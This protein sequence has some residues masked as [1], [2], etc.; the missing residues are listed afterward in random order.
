MG[1]RSEWAVGETTRNTCPAS[2]PSHR[3]TTCRCP[4]VSGAHPVSRTGDLTP[5]S[6]PQGVGRDGNVVPSRNEDES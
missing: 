3:G 5:V 1:A 6:A 2:Y 4:P